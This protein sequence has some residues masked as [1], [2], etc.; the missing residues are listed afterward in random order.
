MFSAFHTPHFL[1]EY[2]SDLSKI[3][4][5]L[6]CEPLHYLEQFL[7]ICFDTPP[8]SHIVLFSFFLSLLSCGY[9]VLFCFFTFFKNTFPWELPGWL[10]D[11]DMSCS[12]ALVE[13]SK[14]TISSLVH[15]WPL[16]M[17][18]PCCLHAAPSHISSMSYI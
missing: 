14:P 7:L 9:F 2:S 18:K 15:S 6:Q 17:E 4:Y 11:P 16:L 1:Q 13:P 10:R 12:G 3:H 8:V 5:G